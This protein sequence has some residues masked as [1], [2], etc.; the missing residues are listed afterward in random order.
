MDSIDAEQLWLDPQLALDAIELYRPSK[1]HDRE[2]RQRKRRRALVGAARQGELTA[3]GARRWARFE[4]D[5]P[6]FEPVILVWPDFR[7]GDEPVGC[8]AFT[9]QLA[10]YPEFWAEGRIVDQ[11]APCIPRDLEG[12]WPRCFNEESLDRP[13]ALVW[14][15]TGVRFDSE[16]FW[17]LLADGQWLARGDV[18][19]GQGHQLIEQERRRGRPV[20]HHWRS[21]I[22][23]IVADAATNKRYLT[24]AKSEAEI[25]KQLVWEMERHFVDVQRRFALPAR[26]EMM[27]W[28]E[29]M[30]AAIM[31]KKRSSRNSKRFLPPG[32]D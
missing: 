4:F 13:G 31:R 27:Q 25:A 15:V 24:W 3:I 10:N 9:Y 23:E 16:Q 28:V 22:A 18:L 6:A 29:P 11:K 17:A 21:V 12:K 2:A 20:Q 7:Y 30:A 14:D 5:C 19:I 8:S 32:S 26:R 1:P